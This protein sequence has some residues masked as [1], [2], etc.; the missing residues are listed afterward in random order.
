MEKVDLFDKTILIT[1]ASD[2]IGKETAIALSQMNAQRVIM[3]CRASEKSER[4]FRDISSKKANVILEHIDL[5]D[6]ASV[7][8]F[9]DRILQKKIRLDVLINNAGVILSERSVTI[10]GFEMQFATNFLGHFLLTELLLKKNVFNNKA[11]IINLSS[12]AMLFGKIDFEDI[13]FQDRKYSG[14]KAYTQSKLANVMYANYLNRT[15]AHITSYSVHPGMVRTRFANNSGLFHV[16]DM[17]FYPLFYLLSKSPSE[18]AATSIYL[19]S[20]PNV[21]DQ[22]GIYWFNCKPFTMFKSEES[23]D[24]K[25]QEQLYIYSKKSVEGYL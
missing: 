19:A 22:G 15:Y 17:I 13:H 20:S 16:L 14:W 12:H 8:E 1:G 9:V 4:A 10:D 25:I 6:L 7:K 24:E 21:E 3:A 5:S 23:H 18:G 2:G 11:R